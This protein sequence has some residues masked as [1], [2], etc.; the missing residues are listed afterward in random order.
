MR[1]KTNRYDDERY[2]AWRSAIFARDGRHCRYANCNYHGHRLEVHHIWS[3]NDFPH[4]RYETSN[5]IVLCKACHY[6]IRHN[7]MA[8]AKLFTMIVAQREDAQLREKEK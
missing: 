5:G 3:Y 4:L 8:Y 6:A 1:E 7:P 2:K